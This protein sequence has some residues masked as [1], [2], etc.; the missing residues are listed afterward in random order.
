MLCGIL[1]LGTIIVKEAG[2]HVTDLSGYDFDLKNVRVNIL[3]TNKLIHKE[4]VS[5]LTET[6]LAKN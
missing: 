3:A 4:L 1:V 6:Q 2:G 5:I